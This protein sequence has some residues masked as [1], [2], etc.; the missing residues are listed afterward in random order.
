VLTS[1]RITTHHTFTMNWGDEADKSVPVGGHS[2]QEK[3]KNFIELVDGELPEPVT[4][5][6]DGLKTV[7][8][9][10]RRDDGKVERKTRV[11]SVETRKAV[12]SKAVMLRRNWAKFGVAKTN[13][14]GPDTASTN[15]VSDDIYL[16]LS[17]KKKLEDDGEKTDENIEKMLAG[18]ARLVMCR[19]CKGEHWTTKCP[20]KD[21]LGG[22]PASAAG[23]DG[24]KKEEGGLAPKGG[25]VGAEGGV[26][27]NGRYVA[28]SRRGGVERKGE[29]MDSRDDTATVR[30]TNLSENTR[31]ED[32]RELFRP[33][34]P[35]S[36][37]YVATDRETGAAR[38]FAFINFLR[39]DDAQNSIDTLHGHGYDHLILQVE[40]AEERT[41]AKK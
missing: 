1:A 24:E 34:G 14:P 31:E 21:K 30:I 9:Y 35:I 8:T 27:T 36:R 5:L 15:T 40:W 25:G 23:E 12:V 39:K 28:P 4:T 37:C 10:S 16:Q 13:P 2:G 7:V 19:I 29:S 3:I 6:A 11:F 38:G 32:L 33:F 20:Y 22:V 18:K 26:N 41:D 17:S